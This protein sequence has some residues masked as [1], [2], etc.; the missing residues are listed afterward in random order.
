MFCVEGKNSFSYYAGGEVLREGDG[1]ATWGR[2][3]GKDLFQFIGSKG[4]IVFHQACG[5][6]EGN[7]KLGP[8]M[9][10]G[11]KRERLK[12]GIGWGR[13]GRKYGSFFRESI[14]EERRG[15]LYRGGDKRRKGGHGFD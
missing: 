15:R 13:E 5:V 11:G 4:G 2:G 6:G 14:L 9:S 7:R 12:K 8:A 3:G 1:Q 10:G